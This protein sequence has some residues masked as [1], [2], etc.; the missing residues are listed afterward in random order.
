MTEIPPL[1][2]M[3]TVHRKPKG[4]VNTQ[5]VGLAGAV[6]AFAQAA[7]AFTLSFTNWTSEQ[8]RLFQVLVT[9][10]IIALGSVWT[11]GKVWSRRSVHKI[12]PA[13]LVQ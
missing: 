11:W 4:L 1:E 10:A 13:A 3:I 9:T 7:A 6:M 5:A 2:E 12:D 8:D